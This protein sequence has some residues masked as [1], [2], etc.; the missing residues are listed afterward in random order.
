MTTALT[1]VDIFGPARV[2]PAIAEARTDASHAQRFAEAYGG[3]QV[4][5]N[6]RRNNWLIFQDPLWRPDTDG[7]IYRLALEFVRGRQASALDLSD[8]KLKERV[9]KFTI[10][11]ES[12]PNLDRLV[13]LAKNF[14]PIADAG[15]RWD[16]DDWLTGAPN[17]VL[18][19]RTG[20]LRP[21]DPADRITK[22]LGVPFDP[23]A[24]APRWTQ[25]IDQVF[26]GDRELI[27]FIH[28][29]LGY[30]CTGITR[31][32]VLALFW[33]AGGNG[34]GVLM[35]L[36]AHVLGDYFSNMS[37]S[38]IELK[39]R[40]TIPSDLAALEGKRLV[41]ASESGEVRLNEPRVKALTG[42][43]PVT[44]RY[45]YGE[46]FTFTP[47]AKFILAT[48]TK[49]IVADN[50]HGFWRR[51]KLVPFT[52]C[53]EGSARDEHLE[54]H[55]KAHEGSGIL[56]WLIAGCLDWQRDGLGEPAAVRDATDEYRT[57]SD[58]LADFIAECC[59]SAVTAVTRGSELFEAYGKWADRQRLSRAERL[60]AKDF[61][62]R[63]AERF[64]RRHTNTGKVYEGVRL[65]KSTLW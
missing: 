49:P 12:K 18:D 37:F 16:C 14:P 60:N 65:I 26:D 11:A 57:D 21:G 23:A 7:A 19:W 32:Q 43:D 24:T 53:F 51:L 2:G 22:S 52:R 61:G 50:S 41:T 39:Q 40:A 54:D 63:M 29:Y 4:V 62:R 20:R 36:V 17:G 44:A 48:N 56:N 30:A 58:P 46:Q 64:N 42:S 15:D 33:G 38:T 25:F 47:T 55:L 45:L 8:L 9:L 5:H 31:E 3:I 28:R 1:S 27:G 10:A 13:S 34:K 59:E 6:H 35:H